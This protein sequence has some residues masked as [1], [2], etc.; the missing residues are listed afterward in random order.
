[1]KRTYPSKAHREI[2]QDLGLNLLRFLVSPDSV[3]LYRA[4]VAEVP[5]EPEL[6]QI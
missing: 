2:L 4:L 1:M 5:R 3:S 6:G